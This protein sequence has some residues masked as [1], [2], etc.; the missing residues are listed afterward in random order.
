MNDD[1]AKL[2]DQRGN[3][4]AKSGVDDQAVTSPGPSTAVGDLEGKGDAWRKWLGEECKYALGRKLVPQTTRRR[5]GRLSF[6]RDGHLFLLY[7]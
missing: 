2:L 3:F 1:V 5:L 7:C 6:A 4:A